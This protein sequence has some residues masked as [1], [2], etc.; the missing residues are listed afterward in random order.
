MKERT[1]EGEIALVTGAGKRVVRV[2][3]SDEGAGDRDRAL[4]QALGR[5]A[6]GSQQ[7]QRIGDGD[8]QIQAGNAERSEPSAA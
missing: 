7:S 4:A 1:L 6:P 8:R 3:E 2:E 5:R